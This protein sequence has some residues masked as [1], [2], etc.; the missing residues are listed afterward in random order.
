[1]QTKDMQAGRQARTVISRQTCRHTER[2]THTERHTN[3]YRR[4]HRI[5]TKQKAN[6]KERSKQL[7][8]P[9]KKKK[10]NRILSHPARPVPFRL[11]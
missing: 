6:R 5:I 4:K 2:Q 10:K 9:G 7:A 1:M 11:I 3:T 8:V